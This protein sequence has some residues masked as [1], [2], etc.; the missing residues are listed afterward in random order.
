MAIAKDSPAGSFHRKRSPFLPEEGWFGVA[1]GEMFCVGYQHGLDP[2]EG[3]GVAAV[4]CIETIAERIEAAC[5]CGAGC[6]FLPER[7]L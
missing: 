3:V 4:H 2:H 7:A 1:Q 6:A 5:G